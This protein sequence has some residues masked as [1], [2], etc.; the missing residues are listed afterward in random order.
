MPQ[1]KGSGTGQEVVAVLVP[2]RALANRVSGPK[3]KTSL[4]AGGRG[5]ASVWEARDM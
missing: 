5:L 1:C 2:R 3:E 4:G